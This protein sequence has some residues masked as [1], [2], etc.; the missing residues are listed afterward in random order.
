MRRL[1]LR[2]ALGGLA[3]LGLAA[4]VVGAVLFFLGRL[5]EAA[6]RTAFLAGTVAW[7]VFSIARGGR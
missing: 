2:H 6:F 3:L 5:S 1:I 7:F 4:C